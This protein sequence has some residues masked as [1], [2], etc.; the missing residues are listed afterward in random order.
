MHASTTR[1]RRCSQKPRQVGSIYPLPKQ[2]SKVV[3]GT[4]FTYIEAD[5]WNITYYKYRSITLFN[6]CS[7]FNPDWNE[8]R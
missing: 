1:W 2:K 6:P 8:T 5:L 3:Q 7:M 4:Y